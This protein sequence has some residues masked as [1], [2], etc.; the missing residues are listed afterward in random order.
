[1][2]EPI[3]HGP[4]LQKR[5]FLEY[6][7]HTLTESQQSMVHLTKRIILKRR[8]TKTPFDGQRSCRLAKFNRDLLEQGHCLF[9]VLTTIAQRRPIYWWRVRC[10][11]IC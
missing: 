1:M 9:A 3:L 10:V 11:A 8:L 7:G 4:L 2:A 6:Y 5:Y